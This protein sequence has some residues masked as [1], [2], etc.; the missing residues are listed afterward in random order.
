LR[1]E[2][3]SEPARRLAASLLA[4][5]LV[6]S[7]A[8]RSA[9][10][11]ELVAVLNAGNPVTEVSLKQLRLIFGAYKRSWPDGTP[12][13]LLLPPSGS[14]AMQAMVAR[15]FKRQSEDAVSQYYVDLVFQQ[16]LPRQPAQLST[17]ESLSRVRRDLG[18]IAI[19]DRDD[20]DDPAGLRL[21][22]VEGL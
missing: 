3:R 22:P 19:A 17:R 10:A 7:L 21:V 4:I 16:K 5:A 14:A 6:G 1:S 2:R 18:A 13:E 11:G 12:I 8:A 20:V 9:R 15:V